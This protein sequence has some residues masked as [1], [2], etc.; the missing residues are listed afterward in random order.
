MSSEDPW[1]LLLD[2]CALAREKPGFDA[3]ER[4]EL[5]AVASALRTAAAAARDHGEWM[6]TLAEAV[7]RPSLPTIATPLPTCTTLRDQRWLRD[8]AARDQESLRLAL[9]RFATPDTAPIDRY[10]D[11]AT[12]ADA[13]GVAGRSADDAR[14]LL[15]FG[16]LLNFA[17][18]PVSL[19]FVRPGP[20]RQLAAILGYELAPAASS[21]EHYEQHLSLA[22][23]VRD[24]LQAAGVEVRD[25]LD[26]GSLILNAAAVHEFWAP[27]RRCSELPTNRSRS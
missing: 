2:Y 19:P 12:A 17:V 21:A 10:A 16:S 26:V 14:A 20:Y 4:E 13:A 6:G 8:W 18:D 5:E 11:F 3:E 7:L 22:G 24:R 23:E 27:G 25:M 15:T 9:A 1:A